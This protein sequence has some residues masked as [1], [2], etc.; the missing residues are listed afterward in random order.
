MRRDI[1]ALDQKTL[2][3][4]KTGEDFIQKAV[5]T[6]GAKTEKDIGKIITALLTGKIIIMFDGS[7]TSV[8]IDLR[9]YPVRKVSE[10]DK[11]KVL[12]GSKDGFVETIIFNT[13]LIRRR[14]RDPHLVF[15]MHII[16]D[17]SKTEVAIGYL[18][19]KVDKRALTVIEEKIKNL[20]IEALTVSGETLIEALE[21]KK[22]HNPLPK[23]RFTERPDVAAAKIVEGKIVLIIDNTPCV[24]ILPTGFLDFAQD[25]DDYYMPII[26]G[27]YLKFVRA[28][29]MIVNLLLTPLY[30]LVINNPE[31][32][33]L[34]LEF[35]LPKV[36]VN[37]PIVIQFLI[38]EIAVDGLKLASL[39]TPDSLGT[40]LS[41]IGG[42]ILGEYAV[43]TGW[44]IPHAILYMALV[45]LSSFT[46][47]SI[48][49]GYSIKFFRIILLISAGLFGIW[50]L[51]AGLI[52]ISVVLVRTKTLTGE[53][54]I[55]PVYPFDWKVLKSL[56]FR[57]SMKNRD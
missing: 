45:A 14:I 34:S 38:L 16:G 54:Y 41:V 31:A 23:V 6:I 8:I 57:I 5:S 50:G 24:M 27:N 25:V 32:V 1:C 51:I 46:Q 42:L 21:G 35:L 56:L 43:S 33:P 2:D 40:S 20:K 17:V 39:N 55:Y 47:P 15:S 36:A 49:M 30:V 22:W 44:L 10:P 3:E 29:I 52:F 28:V 13:T 7:E 26:T 9:I 19:N 12:R 53:S 11:E 4:I 37:V 48:E 18:S